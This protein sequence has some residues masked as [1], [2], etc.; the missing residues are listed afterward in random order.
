MASR[1]RRSDQLEKMLEEAKLQLDDHNLGRRLLEEEEKI[2]IQKKV[3]IF[4]RKLQSM[5]M[6]LDEREIERM[7]KREEIRNERVKDRLERRE[8]R[9]RG[10]GDEL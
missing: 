4:E 6:E 5:Q 9:E 3:D 8:R 10:L 7:L 2:K 1:K